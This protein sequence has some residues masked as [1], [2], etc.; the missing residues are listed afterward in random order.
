MKRKIRSII[1]GLRN[2]WKWLPIIWHDR[3]WDYNYLLKIMYFKISEMEKDFIASENFSKKDLLRVKMA[4]L[5]LKRLV[6]DNYYELAYKFHEQ[7]WGEIKLKIENSHLSTYY[8]KVVTFEDNV[9]ARKE[10]KYC[11]MREIYLGNQDLRQ[12]SEILG[13]HLAHWW[14]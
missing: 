6:D 13:K 3:D 4:R 12:L 2:L 10:A 9:Q 1:M 5:L 11:T 14:D 7:K 8:K